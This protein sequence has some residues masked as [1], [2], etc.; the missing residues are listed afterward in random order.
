MVLGFAHLHQA[1]GFYKA[2]QLRNQIRRIKPIFERLMKA[3]NVEIP[4]ESPLPG[5]QANHCSGKINGGKNSPVSAHCS[6]GKNAELPNGAP[7]LED[8]TH[9]TMT[10]IYDNSYD[11]GSHAHG[12]G[13]ETVKGMNLQFR[14]HEI[15]GKKTTLLEFKLQHVAR[16]RLKNLSFRITKKFFL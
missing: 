4:E 2:I 1:Q 10:D 11:F 9:V 13:G 15:D 6:K 16:E 8:L 14:A 5:L 3:K 7:S 12:Y